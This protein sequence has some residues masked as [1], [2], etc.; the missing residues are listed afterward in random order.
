MIVGAGRRGWC[1]QT[2]GD[3]LTVEAIHTKWATQDAYG[4]LVVHTEGQDSSSRSLSA[5]STLVNISGL[6]AVNNGLITA[7][8]AY[9]WYNLHL[10]MISDESISTWDLMIHVL[11]VSLCVFS[12]KLQ[13][14]KYILL[15][16]F[17]LWDASPCWIS[18]SLSSLIYRD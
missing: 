5:Q 12:F 4:R 17:F 13:A 2:D 16:Y 3:L 10:N 8:G 18:L 14:T 7:H 6:L 9:W 15:L 1:G 11:W